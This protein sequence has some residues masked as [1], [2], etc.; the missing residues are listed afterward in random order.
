MCDLVRYKDTLTVRITAY[1]QSGYRKEREKMR[2]FRGVEFTAEEYYENLE[3]KLN[4]FFNNQINPY[5]LKTGFRIPGA[6]S[7]DDGNVADAYHPKAYSMPLGSILRSK[8]TT[9]LT[10]LGLT[11]SE[12]LSK[13]YMKDEKVDD[14]A[15]YPESYR[16]T[17]RIANETYKLERVGFIL[18]GIT[19][20]TRHIGG[21]DCK[22]IELAFENTKN[23][24]KENNPEKIAEFIG[25][26][27][28]NMRSLFDMLRVEKASSGY[29]AYIYCN[30]FEKALDLLDENPDLKEKVKIN[31]AD[32]EYYEG[33]RQYA[34]LIREGEQV[35]AKNVTGDLSAND[36]ET[37]KRYKDF[38]YLVA[39]DNSSKSFNCLTDVLKRIRDDT[40]KIISEASKELKKQG[41]SE[42]EKASL[43]KKKEQG[44]YLEKNIT[45]KLNVIAYKETQK[46]NAYIREL[47]K[48]ATEGNK[49]IDFL[50]EKSNEVAN[51]D[52]DKDFIDAKVI[53]ETDIMR[54]HSKADEELAAKLEKQKH[55][56]EVNV[57]LKELGTW[58]KTPYTVL[59]NYV[60]QLD[61]TRYDKKKHRNESHAKFQ[62][63]KSAVKELTDYMEKSQR[64][65]A[66]EME[67]WKNVQDTADAYL[68]IKDDA[69]GKYH[70]YRSDESKYANR[71]YNLA[72]K[73][74]NA[75][76]KTM[77][78][79][80][81]MDNLA[82]DIYNEIVS[83]MSEEKK[84]DIKLGAL[85]SKQR[86]QI[87]EFVLYRK[88]ERVIHSNQSY[89]KF[90]IKKLASGIQNDVC[91]MF[92]TMAEIS[93]E[94]AEESK[95]KAGLDKAP[96]GKEKPS[97]MGVNKWLDG[98]IKACEKK[99][100]VHFVNKANG[101]VNED[102]LFRNVSIPQKNN[103]QKNNKKIKGNAQRNRGMQH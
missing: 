100:Y 51:L 25:Q 21:G 70:E 33:M 92:K 99:A 32:R 68:E 85:D 29:M 31:E 13:S 12:V 65:D 80:T 20:E 48:C 59:Q 102:K 43:K 26:G 22:T 23:L 88:S 77:Y 53:I 15:N 14:P 75:A 89:E 34:K 101:V 28:Q 38:Q 49:I 97:D 103:V 44:R 9:L 66:K 52:K 86:K 95:K 78:A 69:S 55:K 67:L 2:D 18:D 36:E 39:K 8:D 54:A 50:N 57:G 24:V 98:A 40:E 47:G 27:L 73:L 58:V 79:K 91:E 45:L 72:L 19:M 62:N 83:N 74:S 3:R 41:L 10:I 96:L 7:T 17:I 82:S 63:M 61:S 90:N 71:R 35:L 56:A 37:I 4:R 42:E 11:K 5:D 6:L 30:I 64:D 81:C 76:Q 93:E 84:T 94:E 60:N 1:L 87:V 16:E 46:E